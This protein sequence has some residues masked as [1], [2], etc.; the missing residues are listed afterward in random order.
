MRRIRRIEKMGLAGIGADGFH[1]EAMHMAY[2]LKG[3]DDKNTF[4]I[5]ELCH[6]QTIEVVKTRALPLGIKIR[7]GDYRKPGDLAKC[8]GAPRDK[9][10]KGWALLFFVAGI[11]LTLLPCPVM[12]RVTEFPLSYGCQSGVACCMHMESTV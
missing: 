5:S 8:F 10:Q 9:N 3:A 12:F 6:P 1:A 4:F 2:S 11:A 7:I